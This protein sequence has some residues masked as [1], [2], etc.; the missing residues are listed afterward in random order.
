M[1]PPSSS[2]FYVSR[3]VAL[4]L[5][6]LVA[7]LLLAL[8]VLA[9][10]YGHCERVPPSELPGLGDSEA[11]SSPP[12]RQKATPTPKPSSAR[13]LTVTTTPSDWRPPGPWDQLRLPPWLVPLHYDLELWPRLRPDELPAGSLPF[14]G[15]V[16]ITVRCTVATSRLLLHSVFQDCERAEVRGPLSPGTGNTTVGRV[17]VDDVWFAL[18]TEYMVLELSEPLKPG[19]SY[20][21]QLSFSGLVN[22]DLREGLFLNVYTDQGERRALLA[23]QL[24]PTFARYVFPCFDEPALKATFNITMIH[25]PSYVALSNM[26]KLGQS[27]KEDVNGSKWTVT[28]FSTTPH[29]PT[30]LVAFVICD[31]DHVNRTERGKEIRI[32]ARKDAIANGSA[33]FALNITGPI[34]SF[35]EDL[36]NISYSLPKTDIIA[37]PSFDNHAM[38]NWGLMIFDES[39]LL[40]E[41]KDQLTEKKTLISYVVSHEIGHQWF[42]N[43]VTMNWWNNIW[44][45]EG[46]ASYFEFEVINYFNP[47]LPR[48]EIFFSNILHNILRED[49]ALVTRAVA[50]KLENFKTSEIQ[51]LFDIFTYSKG[52]SMARMLSCF[53]NEHLFVSALKS[54]LKTF[55]YSNAEQDDLWRHFQMAIDDQSTI[56]LPAT[57]KNIMDSWTH[58]SGF[59]VIT[60]NVSTGV[61][62]QEPFYLE[63]IKN[64]T[65]LTS[66]ETWIVPILWIKNGTTQPLVWLDQSSKVFPEM[67]VSDSDHDWVILNLNMTGYYRV[68]YDKLGWK[69]LNQQLEK[70]PKAI[71]VIHRLQLIDDAFSL[72]KNNYIEIETALELTK[73]LAEEDEII[74]WHTVLVNLVTRDLVSEVN[75]YDIYSLLKRYL[76]KRLNLIWNIYSTI[77]RENML[78]LQDDYLALISLEKLFVTACWLGL[79]DCLQLS[80]ELFAKWVDHPE[81]E[82]PYP[83]KDV[84][85]CYGIALGSD[86]EWDIL[87]NTY[88]NTTNK[89]EKIQL[90]YAMSCSKDPWI[91]N[92]YMEYAISTSPFTSNETNII[93][94]VAASEVGRY[95]AKD[96]LVNNWQAVSKR[97]G[98]QSLINL[99]YTIGRTVTTDLQI[100]ELQQFFSNM[101]EEHQKIRVHANLQTIKNENLKNKKLS[102]RMAA[103]LRRNT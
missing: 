62:K 71:P 58:Q 101:L 1:G 69:K 96:F 98:T 72:S 77:I 29:M 76:L 91:L 93:E 45:N 86:K 83:I 9:A 61:M 87:L 94:V 59:P 24:E 80:K 79:E 16:N 20:E 60:L 55:S 53:L 11:E 44:L 23:S 43:L 56:I 78:A 38:E 39:G 14:T 103:W 102:A 81:N 8:A 85:L 26:P 3:A 2:G 5:A 6:G 70:D 34:F 7:A 17:P 27:E 47:K 21:L 74:V 32:W 49:H 51:E 12:L 52:A 4:L 95:V 10:L 64:R 65:L 31:Y 63:N 57:I 13:E 89:V 41:P 36:F 46:F 37:L 35:L 50:M 67:Q 99:I 88:T 75:I 28:T 22:E 97:Y 15:R 90:A 25:H 48:N 40:L 84:V 92:R 66:N 82:I 68:N 33:D 54:Y 73:Y 30:Y 18:D 42:G 100:V 19:S